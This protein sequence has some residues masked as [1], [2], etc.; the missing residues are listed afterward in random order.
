VTN[1]GFDGAAAALS[2]AVRPRRVPL[3]ILFQS[4]RAMLHGRD[5]NCRVSPQIIQNPAGHGEKN[6]NFSPQYQ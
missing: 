2:V 3:V 6:S 4:V 1:L 5:Q